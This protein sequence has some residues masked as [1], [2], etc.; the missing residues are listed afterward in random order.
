MATLKPRELY[1][2]GPRRWLQ[3]LFAADADGNPCKIFSPNCRSVCVAGAIQ[4]CANQ[5]A[6]LVKLWRDRLRRRLG[7]KSLMFTCS[8]ESIECWNDN[9]DT[10]VAD[11]IT[12]LESCGL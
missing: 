9:G 5:R 2:T 4:F 8:G 11:V 12:T 3:G 10:D 1:K 7:S 6:D